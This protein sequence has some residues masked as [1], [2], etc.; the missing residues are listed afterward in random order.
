ME[1]KRT[2]SYGQPRLLVSLTLPGAVGAMHPI[3]KSIKAQKTTRMISWEL[4]PPGP[5]PVDGLSDVFCQD[6]PH[7]L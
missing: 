1:P 5:D 6:K 3:G 4:S 7:T 2:I